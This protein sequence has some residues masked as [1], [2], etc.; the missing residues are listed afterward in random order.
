MHTHRF[1]GGLLGLLDAPNSRP[2]PQETVPTSGIRSSWPGLFKQSGFRSCVVWALPSSDELV[3]NQPLQFCPK[4][5][6]KR[7]T[8]PQPCWKAWPACWLKLFPLQ[9]LGG[10]II[11]FS[12]SHCSCGL[13]SPL[14]IPDVGLQL[15]GPTL[16]MLVGLELW[17]AALG[18]VKLCSET[19]FRC[20]LLFSDWSGLDDCGIRLGGLSSG[21]NGSK[22]WCWNSRSRLK[23]RSERGCS[24]S[25]S[26][27]NRG[28]QKVPE[29]HMKDVGQ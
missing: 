28:W 27:S 25:R 17:L 9:T 6:P 22:W 13:V 21:D 5:S 2:K 23:V 12:C 8:A 3:D 11:S 16:N 15:V 26:S 1:V 29:R 7:I 20:C 14:P 10:A 4:R 24:I 18:S 19:F